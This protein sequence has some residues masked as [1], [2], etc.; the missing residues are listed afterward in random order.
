MRRG[1]LLYNPKAGTA[2]ESG[3]DGLVAQ[4]LNVGVKVDV[5]EIGEENDPT[6]A[7]RAALDEGAPFLIVAGGDGS[8]GAV[9]RE[10]IGSGTPFGIIPVGT[11][12]NF[13]LSL[14]LPKEIP[15]ACEL[16]G[17]NRLRKVDVGFANGKP[18]FECAGAGLGAEVFP[19]GEEIKSGAFSKWLEL[20]R[21]AFRY[22]RQSFELELDRPVSEALVEG[23][24]TTRRSRIRQLRRL[25]R[26]TIRLRALM[27]TV[28][29]GPY[30]GMNF[31]VA[32]EAR[33]DDGLLTVSVF[34]RFSRLELWWHFLS[35]SSGRR[36]YSP[37]SLQLRVKKIKIGGKRAVRIHL[38]GVPFDE[39]P[40]DIKL[41]QNMLSVYS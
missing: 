16:I 7:A 27:L 21:K 26:T 2:S 40:L 34:K 24:A 19:L 31:A 3:P 12:N 18:F 28:S 23:T 33:I 20:F 4:L 29:N 17:R 10:L 5:R 6:T 13:A 15:A 25:D 36:V 30:Y 1:V 35:I 22:P 8:V 38:D 39:W 9:A 37:K 14:G 11:Y 32:P 41:S